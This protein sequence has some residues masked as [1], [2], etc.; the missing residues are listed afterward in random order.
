MYARGQFLPWHTVLYPKTAKFGVPSI[1]FNG[2][3][4]TLHIYLILHGD[5]FWVCIK[6]TENC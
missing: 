4:G 2:F 1:I 6:N 3:Y 5:V